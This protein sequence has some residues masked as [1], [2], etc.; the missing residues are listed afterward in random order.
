MKTIVTTTLFA[1]TLLI[2]L[3]TAAHAEQ[4][5]TV[6]VPHDFIV[7][8]TSFPAGSYIVSRSETAGPLAAILIQRRDGGSGSFVLP[9]A[10]DG[11][12]A[13][14]AQLTFDSIDGVYILRK[15]DTSLGVYTFGTQSI[16]IKT[17]TKAFTKP[18]SGN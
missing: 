10:F 9:I 17:A 16:R 2:G 5:L 13:D 1:L 15:I 8:N 12:V 3:Q 14:R 18:S 11:A 4:I 7:N 6:N